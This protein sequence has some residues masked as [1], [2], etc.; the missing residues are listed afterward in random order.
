MSAALSLADLDVVLRSDLLSFLE[1]SFYELNP[2]ASFSDA[3]HLAVIASRLQACLAG[4]TKRLIITLPPRALKSI[5]VSVAFIAW[6]LGR[7]P[8]KQVICASYGQD[9]ADKHARDTRTIMTS[10]FYRR[11]F[12]GSQISPQKMAASDFQTTKHGFRMATSVGGT[13]TGR[14][15]DIIII[16]DP[17]KPDDAL[18]ETRRR[19]VIE[20]YENTVQ[21]RLNSKE[22]GI[23]IIVMQRLH[24]DDLVGHV[25]EQGGWDVLSFPAIAEEDERHQI[26]NVFG[27][28]VYERKAGEVLDPSRESLETLLRI[29]E[30][31]GAYN[32]SSQYQQNPTPL[33]G[34]IVQKEWL[35]HYDIAGPLPHFSMVLQSWDTANK[36][37]QLNDYSVCTT[38]GYHNGKYY[39]LDVVR[40]RLDYPNLKRRVFE[41][42][43]KFNPHKI[44]IEDH[45][46][47]TQLIQEL[48]GQGLFGIVPYAPPSQ[49]DKIMRLRAQT[50][51]FQSGKVLL[52]SSAP[53]LAEFI[54]ELTTSPGTKFD[55]QV[56][57]ITQALDYLSSTNRSLETWIKLGLQARAE[58]FVR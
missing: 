37:G 58:G 36:S 46:S 20:W 35:I 45:G 6:L 50:D 29:K 19:A 23:I 10:S 11:V 51:K 34:A 43:A 21:S 3:A 48:K 16:D 56:D 13:L 54:R 31:I 47:G 44:L 2:Q 24:Q 25:L 38:V 12:P 28:S 52:P 41:L 5:T 8:T 27:Q 42:A 49:M 26:S 32:F 1:Y 55:D 15:G 9:L 53:W 4:G 30:T 17:L 7:D 14:G 18:S 40:E 57:S 39:L 33:G 22:D